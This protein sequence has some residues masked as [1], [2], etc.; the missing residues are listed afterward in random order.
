MDFRM[1]EEQ[2]ILIDSVRQFIEERFD[3]TTIEKYDKLGEFPR[4]IMQALAELDLMGLSIPEEYGGSNTDY[5][6][7]GLVVEELSKLS[8]ALSFV[9]IIA[10]IFG[11]SA[12]NRFGSQEQKKSI[13]PRIASGECMLAL[14]LTEPGAGSDAGAVQTTAVLDRNK[15]IINGTKTFC[16]VAEQSDYI[17][18]GCITNPDV[19]VYKGLS[20]ILVP[21][22]TKGVSLSKLDKVGMK[23]VPTYE[24]YF[25]NVEVPSENLLGEFNKGWEQLM[26]MLDMARVM[27]GLAGTG[28]AEAA[29]EDAA[30]YANQRVQFNQPI[31][32][33]Q[34]I[35]HKFADMRM[36]IDAARLMNYKS[37]WMLDNR[38]PLR[39]E[40][41]AAKAYATEI[42]FKVID[43]AMQIMGGIGYCMASRVQRLWRDSRLLRIVEG[44]S[45]IQRNIIGQVVLSKYR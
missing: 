13:L 18:A 25:K 4:E 35:Q 6:T 22:N 30:V 44:T 12:I 19:P 38:I 28:M 36:T 1:T 24:V 32:K 16:T 14:G 40:S 20:T 45:E 29:F 23:Y 15:F 42:S 26:Q 3:D 21:P 34:A 33:F 10:V 2:T 31:A 41:A 8:G 7:Q 27:A 37:L 43:D 39:Y 9:Y 11:G 17:I 5:L